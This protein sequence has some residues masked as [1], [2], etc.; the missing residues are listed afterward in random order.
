AGSGGNGKGS[1]RTISSS[2]SSVDSPLSRSSMTVPANLEAPTPRPVKPAA[3]ATFLPEAVVKNE[4]HREQVSI[5]P[6]HLWVKRSPDSCGKV[7]KKC[8]AKVVKV[9]GRWS[10]FH[11]TCRP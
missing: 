9:S 11:D 1:F 5:G 10:Y 8:S 2:V 7:S 4:K 6:P 3:I